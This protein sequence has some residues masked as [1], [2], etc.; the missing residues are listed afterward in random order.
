MNRSTC[1]IHIWGNAN[2]EC[3]S[4]SK[5]VEERQSS[6]VNSCRSPSHRMFMNWSTCRI[7]IHIWTYGSTTAFTCF[8]I[9]LGRISCIWNLLALLQFAPL[10][11]KPG[12]GIEKRAFRDPASAVRLAGT[13]ILPA[14]NKSYSLVS[15][16]VSL[17]LQY[18]YLKK[19]ST[20]MALD[21]ARA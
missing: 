6:L 11:S 3:L 12:Y 1:R 21:V 16:L 5:F 15:K 10:D 7:R 20:D 17:S 8:S 18:G 19:Q 9:F 13:R 14:T 4:C 2:M